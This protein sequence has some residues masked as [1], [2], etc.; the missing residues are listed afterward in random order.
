MVKW[1]GVNTQYLTIETINPTST[2]TVQVV[3]AT[4]TAAA[5]GQSVGDVSIILSEGLATALQASVDGAVQA[6]KIP[7][8]KLAR[9]DAAADCKSSHLRTYRASLC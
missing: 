2:S 6:C 3:V 8:L 4:A 5:N 9:R 7:G 1:I